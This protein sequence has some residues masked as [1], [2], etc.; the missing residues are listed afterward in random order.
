MQGHTEKIWRDSHK[1]LLSSHNGA[2]HEYFAPFARCE[3]GFVRARDLRDVEPGD[4]AQII[5]RN[6]DEFKTLTSSLYCKGIRRF[7]LNLGCPFPI[8]VKR[9]RGAALLANSENVLHDILK[10]MQSR[11]DV[12]WSA[13]LRL[14]R[15]LPDEWRRSIETINNLPLKYVTVHP[16]TANEAYKGELHIDEFEKFMALSEHPV[17]YNGEITTREDID[18]V[19]VRWP[20]LHGIM[21]S[22]GLAAR[23]SLIAEYNEGRNWDKQKRIKLLIEL[24]SKILTHY[25]RTLCGESQ[26]LMKIKP[27]WEYAENEIGHHQYK[28]LRKATNM[29]KYLS[30]IEALSNIAK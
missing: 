30:C 19:T 26:M 21:I 23:P 1:S 5:F 12:E 6:P 2:A 3:K 20:R 15:T 17:V 8:Q 14:G 27:F 28:A 22:R 25:G 18:K 16:R 13:K 29:K 7:D 11:E 10:L 24:H 4:T 9:G